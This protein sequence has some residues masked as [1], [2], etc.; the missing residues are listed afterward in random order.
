MDFD[1]I[2]LKN[3]SHQYT[4]FD[5]WETGVE[6]VRAWLENER[7]RSIFSKT[8]IVNLF[9]PK[10]KIQMVQVD[11]IELKKFDKVIIF[12]PEKKYYV[13]KVTGFI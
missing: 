8:E 11:K 2:G 10:S 5:V 1:L 13:M 4:Q 7:S 12:T 9:K 3:N 6:R